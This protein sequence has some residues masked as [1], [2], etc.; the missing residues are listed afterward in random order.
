MSDTEIE[1]P[2]LKSERRRYR[3][4]SVV[5][6]RV[7]VPNLFERSIPPG[8]PGGDFAPDGPRLPPRGA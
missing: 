1:D 2:A 6:K 3:K 8:G 5:S 7:L 4:P